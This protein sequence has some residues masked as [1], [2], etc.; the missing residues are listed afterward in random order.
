MAPKEARKTGG[1]ERRAHE[2][3][4]LKIQSDDDSHKDGEK[5]LLPFDQVA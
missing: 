2:N 3:R 5:E 1:K 4:Q